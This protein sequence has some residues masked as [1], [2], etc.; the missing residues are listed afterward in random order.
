M[1]VNMFISTTYINLPPS[2]KFEDFVEQQRKCMQKRG[3]PADQDSLFLSD[4]SLAE[5][6]GVIIN[7]VMNR[8]HKELPPVTP[9]LVERMALYFGIP[10]EEEYFLCKQLRE[11]WLLFLHD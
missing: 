2:D 1:I 7:E 3:A 10:T 9:E 8:Y 6:I 4:S 11:L 5:K